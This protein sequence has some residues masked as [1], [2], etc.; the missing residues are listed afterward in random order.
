MPIKI[1]LGQEL[2]VERNK[3]VALTDSFEDTKKQ[4]T[5]TLK[6]HAAKIVDINHQ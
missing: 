6:Q 3:L 2:E 4:Q 5:S 1:P